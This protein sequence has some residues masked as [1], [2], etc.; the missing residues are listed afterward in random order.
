MTWVR[1]S[2]KTALDEQLCEAGWDAQVLWYMM[3]TDV[4]GVDEGAGNDGLITP[5]LL[6]TTSVR[7]SK[8][9]PFKKTAPK[10]VAIGLWHDATTV[11]GCDAC[12][13]DGGERCTP[14]SYFI[15]D[16]RSYLLDAKG[17]TDDLH[18]WRD[19]RENDLKKRKQVK[20]AVRNRDRDLCRYCG[21][22]TRWDGDRRS[23]VAG[24][25][26]HV[27]P[28]CRDGDLG[29]GNTVK[30]LVVSCRLCNSHKKHRTPEQWV[31][32]VEAGDVDN[33]PAYLLRPEPGKYRPDQRSDQGSALDST[34][35]LTNGPTRDPLVRVR[36]DGQTQVRTGSDQGSVPGSGP[37]RSLVET[38]AVNGHSNGN[39]HH[40]HENGEQA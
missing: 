37:G 18:R 24:T 15:H 32:A 36:E 21:V 3:L 29:Y 33:S 26:D 38:A 8:P 20:A 19:N 30:N 27:D 13:V 17:K 9:I 12:M 16:W 35:G 5:F 2:D 1:L 39:G 22:E 7:P 34:S 14:G 10:L 28:F 25:Y 4:A 31:A 6:R 40:H 11:Q 23:D